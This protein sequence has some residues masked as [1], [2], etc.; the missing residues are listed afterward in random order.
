MPPLL[1][2][3][4]LDFEKLSTGFY[5]YCQFNYARLKI[6]FFCFFPQLEAQ[7]LPYQQELAPPAIPSDKDQVQNVQNSKRFS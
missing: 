4:N 6:V 2:P 5:V 3:G 7:C 1:F